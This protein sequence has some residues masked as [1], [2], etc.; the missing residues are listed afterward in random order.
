MSAVLYNVYSPLCTLNQC[1]QQV[2]GQID[3][4]PAEQFAAWTELFGAPVIST[5]T[6]PIDVVIATATTTVS[7][8]DIIVSPSTTYSTYE[9]T[10]TSY[11]NVLE[12]TTDYTTTQPCS[13]PS[14]LPLPP[15]SLSRGEMARRN[16]APGA[17]AHRRPPS[18][19]RPP[20]HPLR[21]LGRP[22]C[23]L[24]HPTAPAWRSTR[25]P[26]HASTP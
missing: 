1:L 2:V 16:C 3:R 23:S 5:S 7:Y 6:P 10:L 18:P 22:P 14:P 19:R 9:S 15:S 26:A 20:R 24:P 4:N 13:R 12:V 17:T 21:Q 8:T 11:A 25:R